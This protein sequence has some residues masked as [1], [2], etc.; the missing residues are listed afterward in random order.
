MHPGQMAERGQWP[1]NGI[2]S[3]SV[4]ALATNELYIARRYSGG[5]NPA[6]LT[7][8]G[9]FDAAIDFEIP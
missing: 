2:F 3:V 6:A 9:V 7:A 1:F 4:N 5:K 8:T